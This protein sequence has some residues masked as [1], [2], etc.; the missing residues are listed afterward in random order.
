MVLSPSAR[1][2]PISELGN[3]LAA[4]SAA[5]NLRGIGAVVYSSSSIPRDSI[6]VSLRGVNNEDTVSISERY[7]GGGHRL[8]SSFVV[9]AR[10]F[11]RWVIPPP[12][13]VAATPSPSA[14]VYSV[15]K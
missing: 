3:E 7:S 12:T 13:P 4:L 11:Q 14:K 9:D 8:A 15:T 10:E 1:D 6:K 2:T 5:N